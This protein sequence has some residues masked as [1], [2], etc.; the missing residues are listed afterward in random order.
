MCE[1]VGMSRFPSFIKADCS[2]LDKKG[3]GI[4]KNDNGK[5]F[6]N[7]SHCSTKCLWLFSFFLS[8]LFCFQIRCVHKRFPFSKRNISTVNL[9]CMQQQFSPRLNTIFVSIVSCKLYIARKTWT[10]EHDAKKRDFFFVSKSE[11]VSFIKSHNCVANPS[12]ERNRMKHKSL[13]RKVFS[14]SFLLFLDTTRKNSK[15]M[16][17]EEKSLWACFLFIL[18]CFSFLPP[19]ASERV[20]AYRIE[21]K[22]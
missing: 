1:L 20:H 9:L 17:K 18:F 16:E 19:V 13:N 12:E 3:E 5:S 11:K 15:N 8:F 10:R 7:F 14:L 2:F 21:L 4:K 22:W 6:L